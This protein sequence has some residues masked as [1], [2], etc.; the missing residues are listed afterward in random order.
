MRGMTRIDSGTDLLD[1]LRAEG[2]DLVKRE[3]GESRG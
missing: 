3:D 1:L 2:W